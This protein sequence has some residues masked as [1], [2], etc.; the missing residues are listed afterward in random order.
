MLP[1][2]DIAD[3]LKNP[4]SEAASQFVDQLRKT[5]HGPGFFYLVGHG[6]D[7]KHNDQALDVANQFFNLPDAEREALAIGQ[8]AGF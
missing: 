4:N 2:L 5:C 3:Y 8:S 1:V 7:Q 6:I